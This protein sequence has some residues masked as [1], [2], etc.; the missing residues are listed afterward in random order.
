MSSEWFLP[1]DVDNKV[2]GILIYKP[3]TEFIELELF[4]QISDSSNLPYFDLILGQC[5][6]GMQITLHKCKTFH[7]SGGGLTTRDNRTSSSKIQIDYIFS[8]I[9]I[10][11]VENL[12]FSK[13]TT[14]IYN[15]E[16]WV[17]IVGFGDVSRTYDNEDSIVIDFNYT[18]PK[19]I[20]FN[21]RDGLDGAFNFHIS[22]NNFTSFTK[23]QNY[24]QS[25]T[26]SLIS[27]DNVSF[28]KL[29]YDVYIFQNFIVTATFMHTNLFNIELYS[30]KFS[31]THRD[32]TNEIS[33]PKSIKL[34]FKQPKKIERKNPKASFEMLFTYN[35]IELQFP[36]IIRNWY[37]KYIIVADSFGLFFYQ[38]YISDKYLNILFLNLAQAAES[39]HYHLNPKRKLLQPVEFKE[40]MREIKASVS[41]DLYLWIKPQISNNLHLDIRLSELLDTYCNETLLQYIGDLNLFK[42]D[43][44]NTRNYY[45]HFNPSLKE[46]ALKGT[47]LYDLYVK[48]RLFLI[49]AFL[50]ESGFEKELVSKFFQQNG[51]Q[52][53]NI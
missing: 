48:L 44:K 19:P 26:Y 4:G 50:I 46:K 21:I 22:S 8:G 12:I 36:V 11:T 29:L 6:D 47:E 18:Q 40:K 10:N 14:E 23:K 37:S 35:D 9:H 25:T 2:Y 3:F 45:T 27:S 20:T 30:D 34:Y 13:I 1:S 38:F 16:N 33:V 32:G 42:K 17:D 7:R 53:F 5:L 31:T 52:V 15:L 39:F 28:Q 43:I 41:D 49:S 24:T 51:R